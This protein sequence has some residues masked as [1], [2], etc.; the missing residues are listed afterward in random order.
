[1]RAL[2]LGEKVATEGKK[3]GGGWEEEK[4]DEKS[5]HYVIASIPPLER[6]TLVPIELYT[7]KIYLERLQSY[8]PS[9]F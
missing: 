3:W 2:L 9:I 1:M 4:N 8:D 7:Q 5:G 6:R